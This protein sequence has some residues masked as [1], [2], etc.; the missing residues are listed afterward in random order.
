MRFNEEQLEFIA[1]GLPTSW[2][3][4]IRKPAY[5]PPVHFRLID[6]PRPVHEVELSEARENDKTFT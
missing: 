2:E 4:I 1:H 3:A 5:G 6:H